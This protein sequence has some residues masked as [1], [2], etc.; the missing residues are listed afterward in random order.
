MSQTLVFLINSLASATLTLMCDST[1]FVFALDLV[2]MSDSTILCCLLAWNLFFLQVGAKFCIHKMALEHRGRLL[3][4][5]ILVTKKIKTA[6]RSSEVPT[7]TDQIRKAEQRQ[8]RPDTDKGLQGKRPPQ[9]CFIHVAPF[10]LHT[11]F[12]PHRNSSSSCKHRYVPCCQELSVWGWVKGWN[13]NT[14]Y[15]LTFQLGQPKSAG[16]DPIAM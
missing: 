11:H 12:V 9:K 1:L 13:P 14:M 5:T 15:S 10:I 7:F 4:R 3:H 16:C 6:A 2:S 8:E